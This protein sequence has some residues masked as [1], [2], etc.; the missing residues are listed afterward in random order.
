[1][2]KTTDLIVKGGKKLKGTIETNTSK[3]GT[4]G[5]LA[6]SLLNRGRT[7]LRGV[8]QIEELNRMVEVFRSIG[9]T[10]NYLDDTVIEIITPDT[11][12][13]EAL[14]EGSAGKM[15]S[16][17]TT[18]GALIHREKTMKI[19]H[20]GG[21]RMGE[22][23]IAAH[24]HALQSLGASVVTKEDHYD[25]KRGN[26]KPGKIVM[27]ESGDTPTISA[28]LAASLIPGETKIRMGTSNYMVQDVCY[29]LEK[30]G[31]TIDGVGTTEMTV[32]GISEINDDIE[33]W[34]S[35]D[36]IESM[37]FISMAA[38]TGSKLTVT[39]CPIAFLDLELLKLKT[40]GLKFSLSEE[41]LSHN[42]RTNL[43]DISIEPSKLVAPEVKLHAQPYPGMN[44]DNLPFFV[45]IAT[46]TEG[47][48]LIHDWMWENRAIYFTELNRLGANIMLMDPHRIMVEGKTELKAAQI[49]CPSAL[50]PSM[51]ILVAML[52]AEGVSILRDTYMIHRGYANIVERLQSIGADIG[53][54]EE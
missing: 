26:L 14:N 40:M 42:E 28:L 17:I 11:L 13:L 4:M 52:A 33:H 46:Q 8:P 41:Y 6:A 3:N 25:I 38:T 24:A 10:V 48:T 1:M 50:R 2:K 30:C 37:A 18:V 12:K 15:R 45:P 47:K 39:R 34:I 54:L 9:V 23:T 53:V 36:P 20:A 49:V 51:I 44:T 7:V 19:P 27:Y 43:V 5:L 32:H 21:C 31:V 16:I 35:E 29:F 22:R